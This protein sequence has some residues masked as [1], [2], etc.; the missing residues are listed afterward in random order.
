MWD[1]LAV[2][3]AQC[4]RGYYGE[5]PNESCD[6]QEANLNPVDVATAGNGGATLED[7]KN[8]LMRSKDRIEVD[9]TIA[10][11]WLIKAGFTKLWPMVMLD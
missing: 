11:G 5:N 8:I 1:S 3:A 7:R 10:N 2:E 4:K 6:N 9:H